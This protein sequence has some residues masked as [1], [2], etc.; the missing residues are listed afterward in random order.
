[1]VVL[2]WDRGAARVD[3]LRTRYAAGEIDEE[4]YQER[5]AVLT[6]TGRTARRAPDLRP[7]ADAGTPVSGDRSA[8]GTAN[9]IRG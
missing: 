3:R 2:A 5:L 9:G 1:V 8:P 4:E 6:D 7:P